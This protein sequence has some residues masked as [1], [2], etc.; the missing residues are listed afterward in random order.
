MKKFYSKA[1][2]KGCTNSMKNL[3]DYYMWVKH[4]NDFAEFYYLLATDKGNTDA[5]LSLSTYYNV[6]YHPDLGEKYMLMSA[7]NGNITAMYTAGIHYEHEK[8][9]C[10]A[11]KYYL[12]AANKGHSNAKVYLGLLYEQ[13]KNYDLAKKCYLEVI[14]L[15][16]GE[17]MSYPIES[18][19]CSVKSAL[20]FLNK[21]Y[22]SVLPNDNDLK[23]YTTA[24]INGKIG[25]KNAYLFW[26]Y[27]HGFNFGILGNI[28]TNF[29]CKYINI[30]N[31]DIKDFNYCVSKII[32]YI[33]VD[34]EIIKKQELKNIKYFMRY[35]SKIYYRCNKYK[36]IEEKEKE[37]RECI[38]KLFMDNGSQIFMEHMNF[39]YYKYLEKKL[40]PGG[41]ESIK[42]KNHFESFANKKTIIK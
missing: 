22:M 8:D 27:E 5:M 15:G 1:I 17:S 16:E 41:K 23:N 38:R 19:V 14:S 32:N 28:P 10:R 31:L 35:I 9:Y 39:Y 13:E 20:C 11:K 29:L 4:N 12:M 24:I 6:T 42:I 3:G 18:T 36:E 37:R 40:I 25:F 21:H 2:N 34:K 7:E 33:C 26:H 30:Y